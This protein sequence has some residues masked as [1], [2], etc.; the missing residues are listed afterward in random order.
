MNTAD[1]IAIDVHTH[2]EVS[3][4]NPFDSYSEEYDRAADKYF[5]SNRRPTIDETVAYDR[6]Q[7]I[8]LVKFTV[9]SEAH[10]GRRRIPNEEKWGGALG[11]HRLPCP[12]VDV[13][14]VADGDGPYAKTEIRFRG[15]HVMPGYWR[16]PGLSAEAFDEA[17]FYRTG[18]AVRW[19][20]AADPQAGLLFDGRIA[21]DFKLDTGTFVSV[22]PL[23]ARVVA[24]GG[25]LVQDVGLTGLN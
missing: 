13:R 22:G 24:E 14:E 3:C 10:L 19:V 18:D 25:T 6:E 2:A 16:E 9:D 17:G 7:K 5:G 8:G 1:L 20:D 15:P 12:G 23:R 4:R 21:E 11:P